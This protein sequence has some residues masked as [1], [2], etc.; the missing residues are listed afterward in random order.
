MGYRVL[1]KKRVWNDNA[2]YLLLHTILESVT[3]DFLLS[4]V[5]YLK[6][7]NSLH[8]INKTLSK[9]DAL[10]IINFLVAYVFYFFFKSNVFWKN[11]T[12]NP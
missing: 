7:L 9:L 6:L 12:T 5:T 2:S 4:R 3:Q 10:Q 1:C 8:K 11:V